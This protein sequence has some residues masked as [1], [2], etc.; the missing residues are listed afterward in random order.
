MNEQSLGLIVQN[1]RKVKGIKQKDLA[2]IVGCSLATMSKLEHG[3]HKSKAPLV[4]AVLGIVMPSFKDSFLLLE[5]ESE[6]NRN[7]EK[8]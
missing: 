2:R 6:L 7:K 1:Y 4:L 8:V 5:T 3:V